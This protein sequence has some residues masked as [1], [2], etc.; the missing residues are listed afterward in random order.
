MVSY[1]INCIKQGLK[2]VTN[3]QV[4][5]RILSLQILDCVVYLSFIMPKVAI[6]S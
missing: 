1:G 6:I 4:K 2:I 3:K 5:I